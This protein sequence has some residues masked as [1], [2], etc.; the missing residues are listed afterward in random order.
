M[1]SPPTVVPKNRCECGDILAALVWKK[2]CRPSVGT[3]LQGTDL[4]RPF[5]LPSSRCCP[6]EEGSP[7]GW[8]KVD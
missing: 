6:P 8:L 3:A 1:P 5:L 2:C 4:L 7:G